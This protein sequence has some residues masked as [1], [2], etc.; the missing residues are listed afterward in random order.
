ML[1][2]S[3]TVLK[4]VQRTDALYVMTLE[5]PE[6]ARTVQP[7][8]FVHMEIPTLQA[9][10]LRRPFSIYD[11]DP[12]AGTID[13]LYQVVGTGS[14]DMTAWEAGFETT[15][16]GP[17]GR[18]W[19]PPKGIERALLVGGGVGAAPLYMLCAEL[20]GQGIDVEVVLGAA[21]GEALVCRERYEGLRGSSPLCATDDGSFGAHG[22]ATVHVEELLGRGET[23]DYAAVCGPEPMMRAVAAM[24]CDAG[25]RTQVSM[26]RRMACG[27]G[28]CLSCTC[29]T[30]AGRKRVCMDGPVFDVTELG[31]S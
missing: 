5:S 16:L 2:E 21:T 12:D 9:H 26:E 14:A 7:G 22:F 10:I 31:W 13:I 19:F 3:S 6:I 15:T 23:Y 25:I 24:T 27:I 4:N 28:A 1:N 8:Q 17:I 18:R 11:A 29:D 20:I 30:T